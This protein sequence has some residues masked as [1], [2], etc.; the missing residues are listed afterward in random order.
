MNKWSH[1]IAALGLATMAFVINIL[2]RNDSNVNKL[3]TVRFYTMVREK[4][5]VTAAQSYLNTWTLTDPCAK[6]TNL[7][8]PPL[9]D[10]TILACQTARR[11]L[12]VN[13]LNAMKCNLYS[14]QVCNVMQKVMAG[15]I[16]VNN[17]VTGAFFQGKDLTAKA[18]GYDLTFKQVIYN[19]IQDAP[20]VLHNAFWAKQESQFIVLRTIL[21]NLITI[22]ILANLLVHISDTMPGWG[23]N[24]RL[25]MRVGIFLISFVLSNI[26]L[27]SNFSATA[28]IVLLGIFTPA[29]I[30]LIY[31][32]LFLDDTIDRPW[33]HPYTFTIVFVSVSLLALTENDVLNSMVVTLELIKSQAAAQLYMEVVWYW[34]G[35]MEKKRLK[36]NL[37]EVYQTKQIQYALF[38]GIVLVA[39]FPFLQFIAPYDYSNSEP[40]LKIAPLLFTAISVIGTIFLQGLIVDDY[41]G[42]D[43]KTP[44]AELDERG[45]LVHAATRITGGKLAVSALVL[46][47]AMLVEF[48]FVAEYFRTLRAYTDNMPEKAMQ[49]D[50]SRTYLWGAGLYTPSVYTL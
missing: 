46:L 24:Y 1:L 49:Y 48:E 43:S 38:M 15:I 14:S 42:T 30:N 28:T 32:E 34:T 19:T 35:Y 25:G 50:L 22:S 4:G 31:F 2:V 37:T 16:S 45:K 6:M 23:W 13:I 39:L 5:D 41:Y 21:Y 36:S 10:A 8:T 33:V 40:F 27:F 29:I 26:F 17:S 18:P 3:D 9:G 12:R 44:S 47:F 11:D 20:N 7:S